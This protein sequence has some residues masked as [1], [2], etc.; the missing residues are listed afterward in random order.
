MDR[1][2]LLPLSA[3]EYPF[4]QALLFSGTRLAFH[5]VPPPGEAK[6]NEEDPGVTVI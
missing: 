4:C 1:A 5:Y 3:L 2:A 6:Y